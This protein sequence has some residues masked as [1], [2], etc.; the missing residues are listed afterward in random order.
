MIPFVLGPIALSYLYFVL[1][2]FFFSDGTKTVRYTP[3][4]EGDYFVNVNFNKT[5]VPDSPFKADVEPPTDA[6]RV[7][8]YGPGLRPEGV[9]VGDNGSFKI[10]TQG[11]G[12]GKLDV[13]VDGPK[14]RCSKVQVAQSQ[15]GPHISDAVYNPAA[16]GMYKV[17][18]F[19]AGD[20]IYDSPFTVGVSDP[21]KCKIT[22]PGLN[23]R[24]L[25]RVGKPVEYQLDATKAGPGTVK[26][27]AK[28]PRGAQVNLDVE[29]IPNSNGK[30]KLSFVPDDAGTY[31]MSATHAGHL[32]PEVPFALGSVDP[33]KVKV[34]GDGL[35]GGRVDETLPI[36][37][38]AREAGPGGL[39]LGLEGPGAAA[40]DVVD[41]KDGTFRINFT[42]TT[43]GEYR[44]NMKFADEDV[45]GSPFCIPIRNV[46][47]AKVSGLNKGP[48]FVGEEIP[49]TVDTRKA[50]PPDV[51]VVARVQSPS[52]A[53]FEPDVEMPSKGYSKVKFTPEEPGVYELDLSLLGEQL[54][55]MPAKI[56]VSDPSRCVINKGG[57][58][59][60][61]VGEPVYFT[62]DTAAAGPGDLEVTA[63][64]GNKKLPVNMTP[65]ADEPGRYEVEFVPTKAG[66]VEVPV[67]FAG[68]GVPDAPLV[69]PVADPSKCTAQGP[70][71]AP[72]GLKAHRQTYFDVSTA[73]AGAGEVDVSI[74]NTDSMQAV[75]F[76]QTEADKTSHHVEYAPDTAGH[77]EVN[78]R[79]AGKLVAGSP[80]AISVSDPTR[81]VAYGPALEGDS[82]VNEPACFTVDKSEAGDGDL[83]INISGPAVPE[84][85]RKVRLI[86]LSFCR[87]LV[88]P[89]SCTCI[90]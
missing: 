45:P 70:G 28:D 31:T 1:S 74:V 54:D 7:R 79:F 68:R 37:V 15:D 9:K 12:R 90:T 42:P 16:V 13:T 64:E 25:A 55:D 19:Y 89:P 57:L 32:I 58:E 66:D 69:V 35:N 44:F 41:N 85:E 39:N 76:N 51:P 83:E 67:L 49:V 33:T 56:E 60:A 72:S 81:V 36:D 87:F 30:Y 71:L 63:K 75:D 38:D 43:S 29:P 78:I 82:I 53:D 77:Y 2:F 48:Y 26:A 50:G 65:V 22:G 14:P 34:T 86:F 21:T 6:N 17:N 20:H 27:A 40:A 10:D 4:V 88:M 62:V 8:A 24:D 23:N 3:P 73:G 52:G 61:C 84:V 80:Y 18:V 46:K 5:P 11:A 59:C 47:N